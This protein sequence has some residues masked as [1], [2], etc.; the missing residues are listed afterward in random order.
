MTHGRQVKNPSRRLKIY[1]KTRYGPNLLG[2]QKFFSNSHFCVFRIFGVQISLALRLLGVRSHRFR[3]FLNLPRTCPSENNHLWGC[4]PAYLKDFGAS[5][6]QTYFREA[7]A[8]RNFRFA[9]RKLPRGIYA[10]G[11]TK[12]SSSV[13]T[14]FFLRGLDLI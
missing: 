2:N 3:T 13:P 8:L 9:L 4:F 5:D 7:V 1:D 10:G 11:N 6:L 14:V 12:T